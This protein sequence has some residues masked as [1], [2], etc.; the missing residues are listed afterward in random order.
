MN[1]GQFNIVSWTFGYICPNINQWVINCNL[2]QLVAWPNWL[3]HM[4]QVVW[5]EIR[6]DQICTYFTPMPNYLLLAAKSWHGQWQRLT[7]IGGRI[8]CTLVLVRRYMAG[9][10]SLCMYMHMH[11]VGRGIYSVMGGSRLNAPKQSKN[12]VK[13]KHLK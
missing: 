7:N 12:T 4:N 3:N 9:C 2:R 11:V 5:H 1:K 10:M 13:S 8:N 6:W